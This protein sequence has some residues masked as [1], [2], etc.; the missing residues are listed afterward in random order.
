MNSLESDSVSQITLPSVHLG[1]DSQSQTSSS[2]ASHLK[3]HIQTQTEIEELQDRKDH[4]MAQLE[5][6]EPEAMKA[7]DLDYITEEENTNFL[8]FSFIF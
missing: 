1:D 7:V 5:E 8:R 4:L 6:M 2:I 3:H